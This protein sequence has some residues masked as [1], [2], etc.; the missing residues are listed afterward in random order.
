MKVLKR[1]LLI[2]AIIIVLVLVIGF[3][4]PGK[5][6]VERSATINAP[7]DVAFDQ[8]NNMK[9]WPKWSPWQ[10]LDPNMQ[11]TYSGPEA[12]KGASYSW[13][14]N[15]KV[16]SGTQTIVE[17][18]SPT[19]VK[20]EMHFEGF[21][22]PSYVTF[23]F[24]KQDSG[25]KVTWMIDGDLGNNPLHRWMGLMMD[26]MLGEEFEQGLANMKQVAEA[27]PKK[28]PTAAMNASIIDTTVTAQQAY[29]I[30]EH[31]SVDPGEIGKKLGMNYNEIMGMMKKNNE[32]MSGPPFAVYNNYN[33]QTGVD[34]QACVPVAKTGATSGK[35]KTMEVKAGR[36]IKMHYWGNYNKMGDAHKAMQ[37]YIAQKHLTITGAPWEVYITDPMTEKDTAKW[38]TEIYYP[39]Q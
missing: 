13:K 10:K 27:M 8:V 29:C 31:T 22:Q 16:M 15:R 26:K 25:T 11:V 1:I 34:V 37:D 21:D 23:K 36:A 24:D 6:H 9:N 32:Q 20:D 4:L 5:Y 17:S 19:M 35:V 3:F 14:G 12:G 33:P 7:Q 18:T 38:H 2:L 28:A 39:V 30:T